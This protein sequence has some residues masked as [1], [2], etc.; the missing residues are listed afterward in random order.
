[1][2]FCLVVFE[3]CKQT[4]SLR[5]SHYSCP[6]LERSKT[7]QCNDDDAVDGAD[8]QLMLYRRDAADTEAAVC[9]ACVR[10]AAAGLQQT[11]VAERHMT[12]S[13][14]RATSTDTAVCSVHGCAHITLGY[15][16][17]S[18]AAEAGDDMLRVRRL[19]SRGASHVVDSLDVT[20]ALIHYYGDALCAVTFHRTMHFTALFSPMY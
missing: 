2:K 10:Q 1:M 15:T 11:R 6:L 14:P 4:D 19:A 8:D 18:D 20:D 5:R 3:I 7:R 12:S 17:S 9:S 16:M 13:R